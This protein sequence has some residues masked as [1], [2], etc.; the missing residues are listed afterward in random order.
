MPIWEHHPWCF[1]I[2]VRLPVAQPNS[3]SNS[4]MGFWPY[5]G[6]YNKKFEVLE[7]KPNKKKP[8]KNA[9]IILTGKKTK[10]LF[11]KK[12]NQKTILKKKKQKLLYLN[13]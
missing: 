4:L 5:K 3:N 13:N 10:N 6:M 2:F 12:K 7:P 11:L 1:V 9:A 8:P